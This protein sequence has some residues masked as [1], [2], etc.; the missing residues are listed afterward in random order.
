ML[1]TQKICNYIRETARKSGMDEEK[2]ATQME[3]TK[4]ALTRDDGYKETEAED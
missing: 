4:R 2:V 1:S 3:I